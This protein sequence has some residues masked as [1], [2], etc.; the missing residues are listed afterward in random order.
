M[1]IQRA[2]SPNI[3]RRF[4]VAW[5]V[6]RFGTTAR[7][8]HR[9]GS[10]Y[11]W[12]AWRE[13]TPEWVMVGDETYYHEGFGTNSLIYS[14]VMYKARASAQA[15]LRAMTGDPDNPT[16]APP[17]HPLSKLLARPNPYQSMREY[18]ALQTVF[19]SLTGNAFGFV[20]RDNAGTPMQ[21]WPL[22]PDRVVIVPGDGGIKGY[23]YRPEGKPLRDAVPLLPEDVIHVKLPNPADPLEGMGRGMGAVTPS[24]QSGDVDNMVTAFLNLFFRNGAMP[25]G[26]LKFDVEMD[27]TQ[28]AEVK[29]RWREVYGGFE[30]WIDVGV[31][32]KGGDYKRLGLTFD[33]MGFSTLDE[34][35]ESRIIG[36]FGVPPI[37]I[38][39]RFGL[40]RSTFSNFE[41]ARLA[42]WEDTMTFELLLFGDEYLQYLTVDGAFPFWDMSAVPALRAKMLK[43]ID[44]AHKLWT[45][46]YAAEVATA[47]VGL[48]IER[49]PGSTDV[50]FVPL[51]VVPVKQKTTP[52]PS[53]P[54]PPAP[55]PSPEAET[56]SE[57]G[58]AADKPVIETK[59]SSFNAEQKQAIWTKV[60]SIA[61]GWEAR[62][63]SAAADSFDHDMREIG[64]LLSGTGESARRMKATIQWT[65]LLDPIQTYLF[66]DGAENWR[67]TFAPLI[68]GTMLEQGEFWATQLGIQF[69]V[70]NI[71][72]EAWFAD[73]ILKFAQNDIQV[74]T[75]D[76]VHSL[77]QQG[78]ADG[79]SVDTMTNHMQQMFRQWMD[80]GQ[81]EEDFGWLNARMPTYRA[82]AIARTE[83]IGAANAGAHELFKRWGI[84]QKEWLT[85]MDGRQRDSHGAA[86]GQIRA[87]DE[88]FDVGGHEMMH[89]GDKS[90]PPGEI[91]N[92]RCTELPVV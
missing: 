10:P 87:I 74:T 5:R 58:Q 18:Q 65:Q 76:G 57:S 8:M 90:A 19:L 55:A 20:F 81:S 72:G 6:I 27:D 49:I 21:L 41:E 4:Q 31:L 54:P 80:G 29:Q 59:Q 30:N 64:A 83:T 60:D 61:V 28:I 69:D 66:G 40:E 68:E 35:N 47:T 34:R 1:S 53:P 56:E 42:F 25:P 88:P 79:W 26:L 85:S 38:G 13:Q 44:G 32:D 75:R 71:E 46:G 67:S 48:N 39:T 70:R 17:D 52:P 9:K 37:L 78:M 7:P 16:P 24:A 86:N 91:V 92:C 36:P 89:P 11:L 12:P 15:K 2:A 33:E 82:E 73:Y 62:Y 43:Q 3:L 50:S 77:L 63:R 22:R 51:G 45:M 84:E 14:A 23:L